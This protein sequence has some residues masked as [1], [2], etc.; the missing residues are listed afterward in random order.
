M[1]VQKLANEK[2]G[3]FYLSLD[4]YFTVPLDIYRVLRVIS[5]AVTCHNSL[6]VNFHYVCWTLWRSASRELN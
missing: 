1:D 3:F 5:D 6:I 2:I 4:A